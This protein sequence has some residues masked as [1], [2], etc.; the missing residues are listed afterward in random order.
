[1]HEAS[2]ARA[3]DLGPIEPTPEVTA[4]ILHHLEHR[5]ATRLWPVYEGLQ[6]G[7]SAE[8]IATELEVSTF[9]FV[10]N[11]S[12][13]LNALTNGKLPSSPSMALAS[14]RTFRRLLREGDWSE[15]TRKYL[16]HNMNELQTVA[17]N[18]AARKVE[19]EQAQIKTELAEA[20]NVPGIYVYALPH[21][22]RYRFDASGRTLMKVGHS[23]S[24]PIRRFRNQVRTTAL[25][26]EPI[27]LRIYRVPEGRS[28]AGVEG[29]FH[30]LLEAADHYRSVARTAGR[31]WFVTSTRFLDEVAKML[32][33]E[34]EV[35]ASS[36][37]DDE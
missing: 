32:D 25:P 1:M 35:V 8:Q 16:Q 9:T 31:E 26:E 34:I 4:E 10:W 7:L 33:L 3:S 11:Y 17:D 24:D 28:S 19:D 5:D 2:D 15:E 30:R 12:Q 22:L 14:A 20:K 27:L 23:E 36:E 21:Y 6:K 37:V 18:E 29:Q 13:T